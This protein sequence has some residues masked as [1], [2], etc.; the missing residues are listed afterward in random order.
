MLLPSLLPCQCRPMLLLQK[1]THEHTK[2]VNTANAETENCE[3]D[4][5]GMD[6]FSH[7]SRINDRRAVTNLTYLGVAES[8]TKANI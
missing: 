1:Q 6:A 3:N 8:F 7:S 4:T 2:D 5:S